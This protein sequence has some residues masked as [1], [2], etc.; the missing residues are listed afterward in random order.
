MNGNQSNV[1]ATLFDPN[2]SSTSLVAEIIESI[3]IIVGGLL[4]F[5]LYA[6]G[7][8]SFMRLVKRSDQRT[9]VVSLCGE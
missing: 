9:V 4:M 3:V 7:V 1:N 2:N 5:C 6:W 8:N